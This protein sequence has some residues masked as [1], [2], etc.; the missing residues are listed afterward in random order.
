MDISNINDL[1]E[2]VGINKHSDI[3][4]PLQMHVVESLEPEQTI[5]LSKIGDITTIKVCDFTMKILAICYLNSI[6]SLEPAIRLH[7]AYM[8]TV[9][10]MHTCYRIYNRNASTINLMDHL[11]KRP[12]ISILVQFLLFMDNAHKTTRLKI[13]NLSLDM[14][15]L[16]KM[17]T[18]I[19]YESVSI[20]TDLQLELVHLL[21]RTSFFIVDEHETV[22]WI[23]TQPWKTFETCGDAWV[24]GS[25]LKAQISSG[26]VVYVW[27]VLL[28]TWGLDL[29][30][31][32]VCTMWE[33][34]F[35]PRDLVTVKSF[36]Q[37]HMNMKCETDFC[38]LLD[39]MLLCSSVLDNQMK[40]M[41]D[42]TFS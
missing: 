27:W 36:V 21:E 8:N 6:Y 16:S 25:I 28:A 42:Q 14:F 7:T 30:N 31:T 17:V 23:S 15:V 9:C 11:K 4:N 29:S 13:D 12:A 32:I 22:G 26:Y 10:G 1:W 37:N 5:V 41:S 33:N 20:S 35:Q 2:S 34:M 19:T 24:K 3:T 18:C 38:G 39:N 40:L